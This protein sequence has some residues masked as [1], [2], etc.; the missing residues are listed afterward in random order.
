MKDLSRNKLNVPTPKEEVKQRPLAGKMV[1]YIDAR[2]VMDVLDKV[3]GSE[4][5]VF[6]WELITL[7]LKDHP[8]A[9][10]GKLTITTDEGDKVSKSDVGEYTPNRMSAIKSGVSDALKRCAVQ[11]GV[12]RDLYSDDFLKEPTVQP[13]KESPVIEKKEIKKE[14]KIIIQKP[15]SP[16]QRDLETPASVAQLRLIEMLAKKKGFN[17]PN[18]LTKEK[19]SKL[20]KDHTG[21]G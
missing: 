2:Y 17:I 15:P 3:V 10:K 19:A 12:A 11:F 13:K 6:D 7:P 5:W 4:K 21:K 8:G 14:K 16:P 18:K 1:S 9:I 20:I